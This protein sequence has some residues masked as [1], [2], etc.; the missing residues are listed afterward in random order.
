MKKKLITEETEP[1]EAIGGQFIAILRFAGVLSKAKCES[2]RFVLNAP[3]LALPA[4]TCAPN[5]TMTPNSAII[6]KVKTKIEG[7]V[8]GEL[9][10]G[11]KCFGTIPSQQGAPQMCEFI[12][13]SKCYIETP[14]EEEEEETA[15]G[16]PIITLVRDYQMSGGVAG[17]P[18]DYGNTTTA[19][20]T[21]GILT[22][23]GQTFAT[24]EPAWNGNTRG[25]SCIPEGEYFIRNHNSPRHNEC[26]KVFDIDKV[27]EVKGRSDILIHRGNYVSDSRGCIILGER[28]HAHT[29]LNEGNYRVSRSREAVE[30]LRNITQ[31]N[32][33]LKITSGKTNAIRDTIR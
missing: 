7:T 1:T 32:A 15:D 26:V 27:N 13:D 33:I 22:A 23:K 31:N 20:I 19:G 8:S 3:N 12:G 25:I 5:C 9:I 10:C 11:L 14:D 4:N 6:N 29:N 21:L 28:F 17:L 18:T 24:I 2:G 16:L 30:A